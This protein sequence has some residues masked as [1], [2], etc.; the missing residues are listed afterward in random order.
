MKK[1]ISSIVVMTACLIVLLFIRKRPVDDCWYGHCIIG[2]DYS[3]TTF[4]AV[5]ESVYVDRNADGVPQKNELIPDSGMIEIQSV[6]G[7]SVI[8]L[9]N[10]SLGL[11]PNAV[12]EESPQLIFLDIQSID[13]PDLWQDGTI[14]TSGDTVSAGTCHL[15]GPLSFF[16]VP[17]DAELQPG[18]ETELKI[19]I[20]TAQNQSSAI[21]PLVGPSQALVCTSTPDDRSIY[22]FDESLRPKMEISFGNQSAE[23]ETVVFDGFC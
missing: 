2:D 18:D 20:G 1:L 12:S 21:S 6:D 3:L 11:T 13:F 14:V 9:K 23:T 15:L 5:G 4:I 22:A 10:V 17:P 7:E 8:K 16:L 19:V